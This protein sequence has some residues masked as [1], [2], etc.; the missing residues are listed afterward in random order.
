MIISYFRL[1]L[2]ENGEVLSEKTKNRR[3]KLCQIN[4]KVTFMV[5]L[6]EFFG[7]MTMAI[8]FLIIGSQDNAVTGILRTLTMLTY[9]VLLPLTFFLNSSEAKDTIIDYSWKVALSGVLKTKVKDEKEN[10]SEDVSIRPQTQTSEVS[11]NPMSG[12]SNNTKSTAIPMNSN[13]IPR[14]TE[15]NENVKVEKA[16]IHRRKAWE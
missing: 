13:H 1:L 5:W 4:I 12:T 3:A 9:F 6:A 16:H 11:T 15:D 10:V 8:D 7:C 14:N 2:G